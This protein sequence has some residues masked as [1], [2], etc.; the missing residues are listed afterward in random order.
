MRWK[1]SRISASA[2]FGLFRSRLRSLWTQQ[3]WTAA[4]A[5]TSLTARRKPGLPSMIA[6]TGARSPRATRSS[7]QPFHATRFAAAQLQREQV[8]AAIGENTDNAQHRRAHDLSATAY[9]R[10]KP[11][12][13]EV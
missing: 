7:R 3:S 13:V 8:L 10:C 5:H 9:A 1:S 6:S 12:E 4:R 2:C 11:I